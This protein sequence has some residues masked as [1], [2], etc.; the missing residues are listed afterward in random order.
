M[1]PHNDK[2]HGRPVLVLTIL[3][4]ALMTPLTATALNLGAGWTHADVGLQNNGD[5]I[6][7]SVGQNVPLHDSIFD[8]SYALD[9]VQKKGSQPTPFSDPVTGFAIED[10]E[11]T[12]HVLEP[13][14]FV[15]ANV[16]NL[17]FI[18]RFYL[19][20]SIGLKVKENWSD[21]PGEPNQN[22]G[23]K[24]TD[25]IVHVGASLAVG[26]VLLDV[27]WS[28]SAVGQLLRDDQDLPLWNPNKAD[29]P[30]ADVRVPEEGFKTEVLR[31]GVGYSF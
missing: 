25:V 1:N 20:G 16:P 4:L 6:Y 13:G 21:F 17:P 15:G 23:Y 26:P 19:G 28:K 10:A 3:A 2:A 9:Y 7:L 11:V 27:R 14:V 29:D 8:F 5:G 30:L 31:V 24:E 12:L 22:Y 18:P